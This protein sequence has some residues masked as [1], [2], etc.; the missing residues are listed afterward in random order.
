MTPAPCW[1]CGRPSDL[2]CDYVLGAGL[3]PDTCEWD[4]A[5]GAP[6]DGTSGCTNRATQIVGADGYL[7][8]CDACAAAPQLKRRRARKPIDRPKIRIETC[9]TAACRACARRFGWKRIG[10]VIVCRRPGGCQT[11]SV[12]RCHAH[13][14]EAVEA[15]GDITPEQVQAA[16]AALKAACAELF[17]TSPPPPV[18]HRD[19]KPEIGRRHPDRWRDNAALF[20]SELR[21]G[22]KWQEWAAKELE[23]R[24]LLVELP[25]YSERAL[26]EDADRWTMHDQDIVV[27][28]TAVGDCTLEVKS[29]PLHFIDPPGY[30]WP[31]ALVDTVEGWAAKQVEPRAVL[32]VSRPAKRILVVSA[33]TRPRWTVKTAKDSIRNTVA[34]FYECPRHLLCSFEWL[35]AKLIP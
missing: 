3:G 28:N 10:G 14:G 5:R 9:D 20:I 29:R 8:A 16:R 1:Y 15:R 35:L 12:D 34:D 6:S 33:A 19:L 17:R 32:L 30:P 22:R 26:I 11:D 21:E 18:I 24:G 23:L 27:R 31:T 25:E 13:V 2:L 7:R 4:P